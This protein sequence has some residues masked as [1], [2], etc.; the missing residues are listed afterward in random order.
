MNYLL[1][2]IIII[3]IYVILASATNLLVGMTNLL[4]LGQAA[5]Y[6][7]GAYVTTFALM[8]LGLP[9]FPAILL[10]MLA[11]AILSLVIAYA[12]LRLQ[13]D[14]FVLATLGFQIIV[15]TILYNW[16]PVTK[17]SYGVSGIP[18]PKLFG[19]IEISGIMPFFVLSTIL[20]FSTIFVMHK[21]IHSPFGRA[22][23]GVRDDEI[24][25]MALGRNVTSLK[26]QAFFISS[27]FCAISGF[28]YAT[29]ISY[30][31]PASFNLDEA[32][33]ILSAVIIGGTG[34]VKGPVIGAIFVVVFPE[35]LRFVGLPDSIG[36]NLRL[37]IYGLV[38]IFLMLFRPQGIAGEHKF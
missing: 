26:I 25:M 22:L 23:K 17:G 15:Y 13:G 19:S 35:L 18:G 28:V 20:A 6:G 7:I 5:L 33:F 31:D 37:I 29:Y 12:S 14:Y 8:Y 3:N 10:S 34:N 11:T 4:S 2:I 9:L 27:A 38:L 1:H 36:A 30:I 16:V 21:L 24:S 32:I